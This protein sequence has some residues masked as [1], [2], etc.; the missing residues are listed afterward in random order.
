MEKNEALNEISRLRTEIDRHNYLYYVLDSPE[1]P[2]AEYDRLMRRLEELEAAYP[3]LVTPDSPTQRVGAKPMAAF[4]TIKHTIPMISLANALAREEALE[5]DARVK[6]QL[7]LGPEEKVEYV[8]EP[9]MVL[10]SRK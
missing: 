4:G 7:A 9:K 10:R 1:V 2:D 8:G 5:F 6:R 3:E